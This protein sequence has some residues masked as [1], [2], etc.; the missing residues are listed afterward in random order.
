MNTLFKYCLCLM[1]G[2]ALLVPSIESSA[3]TQT[4]SSATY[5]APSGATNNIVFVFDKA[6]QCG[7]FANGDVWVTPYPAASLTI[8][9]ISPAIADGKNGFEVNPSSKTKQGF[10]RRIAGYDATLQPALPLALSGDVSVVK[11]VSSPP[12]AP[13]KACLPCLQFAAVLTVTAKPV[14]NSETLFRPGY[15]GK[16]KTFTTVNLTGKSLPKLPA[17]CCAEAANLT[18]LKVKARY[19]SVQLDNLQDWSGRF[20]H[21]ADNMPDYGAQLATDNAVFLLRM[22][23]DDFKVTDPV[24]KAALT[25]YLQMAVDLRSMAAGGVKW[26]PSGGHD[27]GRKL[28]LVFAGWFLGDP[29]F[30]AAVNSSYFSEDGQVYYSAKAGQALFGWNCGSDVAYWKKALLFQSV[31]RPSRLIASAVYF[32]GLAVQQ[33]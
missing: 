15:F 20:M 23:M 21:P 25:N 32:H 30:Q 9:S 7:Q 14:L 27:N 28:P 12:A 6:Y 8:T 24:H 18:F 4:C 22:L 5:A 3:A 29:S 16:T 33:N 11:T 13:G 2:L 17:S 19:Q 31:S 26:P 10:D 1:A